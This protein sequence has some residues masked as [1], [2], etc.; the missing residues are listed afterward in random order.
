[1][2]LGYGG[3]ARL[4]LSDGESA[5]YAYGCTNLNRAGNDPCEDGEIYVELRP[6]ASAC[7]PKRTKRYPDGVPVKSAENVDYEKM[8]AEGSLKVTNC[9]NASDIGSGGGGRPGVAPYLQDRT[10]NPAGRGVSCGGLV[11]QIGFNLGICIHRC[12]EMHGSADDESCNTPIHSHLLAWKGA[13]VEVLRFGRNPD[14]SKIL[15]CSTCSADD[16]RPWN[17]CSSNSTRV[18]MVLSRMRTESQMCKGPRFL[19]GKRSESSGPAE[20]AL[21]RAA[22]VQASFDAHVAI[23]VDILLQIPPEDIGAV[24]PNRSKARS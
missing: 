8:L 23:P 9:S 24:P 20:S 15:L 12:I 16:R 21:D 17:F 13:L 14:I 4:V 6:I 11:F 1:M 19:N 5:V 22:S 10:E 3:T 7:A 18:A 2:S